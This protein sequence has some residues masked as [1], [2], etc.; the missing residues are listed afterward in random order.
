MSKVASN[1]LLNKTRLSCTWFLLSAGLLVFSSSTKAQLTPSV[2]FENT[3][4]QLCLEQRVTKALFFKIVDVGIYYQDCKQASNIFDQQPKLLR[5]SYLR[6]VEG[7]QF[8]EGADDFLEQN[9][10]AAEKEQCLSEFKNFN[11]IY[12]DVQDGDYYDLH[13]FPAQGI[14]LRLNDSQLA[15]LTKGQCATPYLNIWFG[16]ESMDDDFTELKERLYSLNN[17]D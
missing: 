8:T 16:Q 2:T 9:L 11:T 1:T 13:I 10:Q 3:E 7:Q 14:V 4:Y 17:S 15:Q 6:E 5:F 12:Q